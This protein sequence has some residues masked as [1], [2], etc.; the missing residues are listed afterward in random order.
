MQTWQSKPVKRPPSNASQATD[1]SPLAALCLQI[2]DACLL[3]T[4]FL[5]PLFFGGRH[6]L[7]RFVFILLATVAA[8]AWFTRQALLKPSNTTRTWANALGLA[9]ISLVALQLLPLPLQWLQQLAPRNT[10]LLTLWTPNANN[11]LGLWQTLTLTPSSTKIALAT[12]VAYVLLFM[13]TVGRL[14]QLADIQRLIRWIALAAILMAAFGILQYYT[15]N[16]LFLWFYQHPYSS[17][18]GMAKG[19]FATPNHFAHFIVL[20]MG[21]LLAWIV[22]QLRNNHK[23]QANNPPINLQQG[24]PSSH[25]TRA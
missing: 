11:Q 14:Q 3:G 22:L 20:G 19:S 2:V 24:H 23:K 12:L 16:G 9:M 4:L 1:D 13:T 25:F 15:S 17:T 18:S 10:S 7:G 5:A 8:I 21:P 6:L